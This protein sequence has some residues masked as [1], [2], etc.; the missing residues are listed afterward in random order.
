MKTTKFIPLLLAILFI[1][2]T[3][4]CATDSSKDDTLGKTTALSTP[5]QISSPTAFSIGRSGVNQQAL[6]EWQTY[7]SDLYKTSITI[8]PIDITTVG[9]DVLSGNLTGLVWL[10]QNDIALAMQK[11]AILPLDEYL[12]DNKAWQALPE[13]YRTYF[14]TDGHLWAIPMTINDNTLYTSVRTDWL[15]KAGKILPTNTA[16]LLEAGKA[17]LATDANGNGNKSDDYL[18]G[19]QYG[20]STQVMNA[21]GLYMQSGSSIAYDPTED[22]IVDALFKPQAAEA[23]SYLRAQYTSGLINSYDYATTNSSN[24]QAGKYGSIQTAFGQQASNSSRWLYQN[25]E[26]YKNKNAADL[27]ADEGFYEAATALYQTLPPLSDQ[28]PLA[29]TMSGAGYVL[30]KD[31]KNPKAV[32]NAFADM[33]FGSV[34]SYLNCT[35]GVSE[36]Y[37][38][39]SDHVIVRNFANETNRTYYPAPNLINVN[40]MGIL[41][42]DSF[43]VRSSPDTAQIQLQREKEQKQVKDDYIE[44]YTKTGQLVQIPPFYGVQSVTLQTYMTFIRSEYVT[45]FANL[46]NPERSI[47]DLLNNYRTKVRDN[48]H[49]EEIIKEANTA[50]GKTGT[51]T[52]R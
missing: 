29:M 50:I 24:I 46:L 19:D 3:A 21:F 27:Q 28:Y 48:Y 42:D 34:Q 26:K 31:T 13:S 16:E 43:V 6:D 17:F 45:L 7:M 51:Q 35:L 32:A 20:I 38:I 14:E 4:G 23:L 10:S 11:G 9:S 15:Q 5:L 49:I 18:I 25:D 44:R 39:G 12:A 52:F 22:C 36:A 47:D 1:A 40:T 30:T 2:G 37:T 41:P 33:L 8:N